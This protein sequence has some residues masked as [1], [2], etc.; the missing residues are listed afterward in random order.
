MT[1][2]QLITSSEP[3]GSVGGLSAI[4]RPRRWLRRVAL[5]TAAAM[6]S[7]FGLIGAGPAM[8]QA[9][10]EFDPIDAV[11]LGLAAAFA[12]L[13]PNAAFASTGATTLR[14]DTGSTTLAPRSLHPISLAQ[15]T[16]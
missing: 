7:T 1:G 8:V 9:N 6:A 10:G 13:T 4:T 5:L 16:T 14:G 12:A 15:S 3:L 2:N 11:E